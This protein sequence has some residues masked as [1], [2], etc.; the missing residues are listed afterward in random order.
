M[1][2]IVIQ[3]SGMCGLAG[4][5]AEFIYAVT[6]KDSFTNFE[7]VFF[8]TAGFFDVLGEFVFLFIGLL[9]FCANAEVNFPV[10]IL[11]V[12]TRDPVHNIAWIKTRVRF[13]SDERSWEVVILLVATL[14][15][16]VSALSVLPW[17]VFFPVWFRSFEGDKGVR[18]ALS[19]SSL[20]LLILFP[21]IVYSM[22]FDH[23]VLS[24]FLS[25]FWLCGMHIM[26]KVF[27]VYI[28]LSNARR[29]ITGVLGWCMVGCLVIDIISVVL[30]L[31]R[32]ACR[33]RDHAREQDVSQEI[34][35]HRCQSPMM[36]TSV[37]NAVL[38]G[39]MTGN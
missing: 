3:V 32:F 28:V 17:A 2:D 15:I 26:E 8:L 6:N 23:K 31:V 4:T 33:T 11:T 22:R 10:R 18:L 34:C 1:W 38:V 20:V 27:E 7:E 36:I 25:L 21:V 5:F 24:E 39:L 12:F 9:L 37:L 35:Y 14:E 29:L 19:I 13:G 16:I 30:I